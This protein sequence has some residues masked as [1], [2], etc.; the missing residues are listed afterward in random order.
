MRPWQG[1]NVVGW[2]SQGLNHPRTSPSASACSHECTVSLVQKD[3]GATDSA[4]E[5]KNAGELVFRRTGLGKGQKTES[6]TS[7]QHLGTQER[8]R[9]LWKMIRKQALVLPPC[10][11]LPV[12]AVWLRGCRPELVQLEKEEGHA[13]FSSAVW[14]LYAGTKYGSE[15]AGGLRI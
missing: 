5:M 2:I 3:G 9:I 10:P 14:C 13:L 11:P 8:K 6:R 12:V 1:R 4:V 15:K 7:R